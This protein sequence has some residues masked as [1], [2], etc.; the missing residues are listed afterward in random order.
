MRLSYTKLSGNGIVGV[1]GQHEFL[2][3]KYKRI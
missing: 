3:S 2:Y 1:L